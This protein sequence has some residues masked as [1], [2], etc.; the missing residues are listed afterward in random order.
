MRNIKVA[1]F[2]FD[3]TLV[4]EKKLLKKM[5]LCLKKIRLW[6]SLDCAPSKNQKTKREKNAEKIY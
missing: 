4:N 5:N 6:S 3:D 2:D 1:A